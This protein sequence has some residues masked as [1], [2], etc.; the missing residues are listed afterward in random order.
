[1]WLSF[2][3]PL[4]VYLYTAAPGIFWED[5]A[6]FQAAAYELGIVHNPSF[7]AFVMLAHLFTRLPVASP[8]WLVNACAALFGALS[9]LMLFNITCLALKRD[10]NP[11]S[12]FRHLIALAI[13]LAFAFVYGVWIQSV[14]AEVYSLNLFIGLTIVWFMLRYAQGVISESRFAT[15]AG[16]LLGVGLANHY[17]ILGA[18]MFPVLL[19]FVIFNRGSLLHW[20]VVLRGLLFLC[21]GLSLYLY[22]PLREAAN[23]VFNW[24]DF[25]SVGAALKSIL[26]LDE[27]LPINQLTVVTPFFERLLATIAELWRSLTLFVWAF[28]IVGFVSLLNRDKGQ[29]TFVGLITACSILVT[30]YAADFS[31]Y[32]LDLYGYLMPAY[33][34]IFIA[35]AV[36]A[37]AVW[38][39]AS[40]RIRVEQR[41]FRIAVSSVIALAL[42]AKA[43]FLMAANYADASKREICVADEYARSILESLPTNAIFLAGEDNSFSPLLCKQVVDEFRRDVVV[44]SAGALLRSDYRRK[45]QAR[46]NCLWYPA[47]W[48]DR[49][50]AENFPSNLAEWISRN[51]E[52]CQI[53]MT[54]SQ[55][56]SPLV[57]KLQPVGFYYT[58]SDTTKLSQSSAA[59]SVVFY[60]DNQTL[61]KDSPDI[62]TREHFGRLLYNL[63]Y[64]YS[65]HSQP[66]LAAKYNRDAAATDSTNVDLMLSCLKMALLTKQQDDQ[67]KFAATIEELDPGNQKLEEILK[68]A[69]AINQGTQS[70]N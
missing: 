65:K 48:N 31:R 11:K 41:I 2:L 16:L 29:F 60:R 23:P 61:W 36:G 18:V 3:I 6:A 51:S 15:F 5:S 13:A 50:F 4:G 68:T 28:A 38:N 49:S 9:A 42:F 69:L 8:Q 66:A 39:F 12:I 53:A 27:T 19:T 20:R 43:G 1:M 67:Q 47:N 37:V 30:A 57:E 44:L 40:A 54:L 64:F 10:K 22:L 33:A 70:G 63:S 17:L 14:R 45:T 25:S 35:V 55:W 58:Y 56:T 24:G 52:H 32:N 59:E 62:T 46:F 7:P 26:R 34:G 21:L